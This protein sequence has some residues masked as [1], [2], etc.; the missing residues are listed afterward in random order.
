V[1]QIAEGL[2]YLHNNGVVH[3]DLKPP[4]ILIDKTGMARLADF[5]LS[6]VSDPDILTWLS[7]SSAASKGGTTRWQAPELFDVESDGVV[8]NSKASD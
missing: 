4:N 1:F 5:G 7:N 6:S 3:G 2:L 8:K